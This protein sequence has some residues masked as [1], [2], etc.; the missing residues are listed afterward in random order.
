MEKRMVLI[1]W[2]R[3]GATLLRNVQC[4]FPRVFVTI[5]NSSWYYYH[6]T[7]FVSLI[8]IIVARSMRRLKRASST[9][10]LYSNAWRIIDYWIHE[11]NSLIFF[12]LKA[13]CDPEE[14]SIHGL[15]L[16]IH[17]EN[18][19]LSHDASGQS[20]YCNPSWSIDVQRAKHLRT[21][22]AKSPMNTKEGIVLPQ[23]VNLNMLLLPLNCCGRF[24][25]TPLP[26]F[27]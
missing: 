11:L 5:Y 4:L 16:C 9:F 18:S 19:F 10:G 21:C 3:F 24:L 12:P 17:E 6:W 14:T 26:L 7:R 8:T 23:R 25:L 20:V 15:I 2:G 27:T 1:F 22:H 13:G